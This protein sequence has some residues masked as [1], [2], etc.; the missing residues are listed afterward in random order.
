MTLAAIYARFSSDSQRDESIEIQV[1]R[2]TQLIGREKWVVGEVYADFAMTG[3]N[4][5]RPAFQRCISDGER[6]AYDVL[7]VYKLDRFAR[8]VE[9]SR[10]YK[11]RL[12]EAGVRMVSVRE[13]ESRDTP[14]G[15]LHEGLDELFAEYYSRNLSVLIREGNQ[16][17][18]RNLKASGVRRYG[19]D[20]DAD[21]HFVL[22]PVEYERANM[23]ADHYL[24][25]GST[26]AVAD[27]CK[28]RGIRN[29]RGEEWTPAGL[30]K[31]FQNE[32]NL[33][34][35]SYAGIRVENAFEPLFTREK[36]ERMQQMFK[37][38][39]SRK[40][41]PARS[42]Y[43]LSS[44][45]W[46]LR[47]GASVNGRSGT[48]ETGRKYTYYGCC[49]KGCDVKNIPSKQLEEA[50]V[51]ALQDMLRD[52]SSVIAM[53][54]SFLDFAEARL[55]KREMLEKEIR[56][57]KIRRRRLVDSIADG[58][59]ASSV[60][61]ALTEAE[62]RIS[63]LEGQ[64]ARESAIEKAALSPE[65]VE[66]FVRGFVEDADKHDAWAKKLVETFI[67]KVYVDEELAIVLFTFD[68]EPSRLTLEEIQSL[69][70]GE[71]P[72]SRS[73]EAVRTIK[74]WWRRGE[75]NSGPY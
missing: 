41:A 31:F 28:M 67:D 74:L 54:E 42:S 18:A 60:K 26:V 11:R 58:V 2:C 49:K 51:S 55:N 57:V 46:C 45:L 66:R 5:K 38:H 75:S 52:D 72:E 10:R 47:C 20:V 15:F 43:A 27:W 9:V 30:S 50:I 23:M 39:G 63:E 1:E 59:P 29:K 13:G 73:S 34:I 17:N 61:E 48:S 70:I 64:L 6:G 22:N 4:D 40:K 16:K 32:A 53:S 68:G 33:G 44:K 7:V 62:S 37:D 21:D 8:S 69:G 14:D 3:T 65:K 25:T 71:L 35:Y 36:F 19:Y 56:E 24:E 12:R